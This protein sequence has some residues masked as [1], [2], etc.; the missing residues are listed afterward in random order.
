MTLEELRPSLEA[1]CELYL[2]G[3]FGSVVYKKEHSDFTI[4][5]AISDGWKIHWDSF[6]RRVNMEEVYQM[7]NEILEMEKATRGMPFSTTEAIRKK[8]E[9]KYARLRDLRSKYE[10]YVGWKPP[11]AEH[12]PLRLPGEELLDEITDEID[13]LK[14]ELEMKK[15]VLKMLTI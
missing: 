5:E 3:N 8:R 10:D 2:E 13:K 9:A 4:W 6:K 11:I 12:E 14:N 1:G 15:M 7:N